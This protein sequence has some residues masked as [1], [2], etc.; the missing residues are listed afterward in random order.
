[1][2]LTLPPAARKAALRSAR[3]YVAA[4]LTAPLETGRTAPAYA[5]LFAPSLRAAAT[6]PDAAALTDAGLPSPTDY[7]SKATPVQ[8]DAFA[9][10]DGRI[11]FVAP[12]FTVT[13]EVTT[14]DG[15]VRLQRNVELTLTARGPVWPITGYRVIVNRARPPAP[16]TTS[17]AV[18]G[19]AP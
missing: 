4:A 5:G 2:G 9:G 13:T 19:D 14:A 12:R 8:L 15:P 11:A 1:P 16:T 18:A 6:G 10:P 3:A 7:R 17:T